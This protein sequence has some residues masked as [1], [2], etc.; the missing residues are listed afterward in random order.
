[1]QNGGNEMKI[2]KGIFITFVCIFVGFF[3]VYS[4]DFVT[5]DLTDIKTFYQYISAGTVYALV[6]LLMIC[7]YLKLNKKR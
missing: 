4:M 7:F 2:L 6:T 1:M 5:K 3:G